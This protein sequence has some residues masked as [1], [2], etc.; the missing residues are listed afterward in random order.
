MGKRRERRRP[1]VLVFFD[2]CILS[3]E[4]SGSSHIRQQFS[5]GGRI[6]RSRFT[7][8]RRYCPKRHPQP[9]CLPAH[10]TRSST[11]ISQTIATARTTDRVHTTLSMSRVKKPDSPASSPRRRP[12]RVS[13]AVHTHEPHFHHPRHTRK[14]E[15][16]RPAGLSRPQARIA[17]RL[18][19]AEPSC[20]T[21]PR[22]PAQRTSRLAE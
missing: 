1:S 22:V 5:T 12:L 2:I 9:A 13:P 7:R 17:R 4:P 14:G 3:P 20:R 19:R 21:M 11:S 10:I 8:R 6:Q 15:R 16:R 18:P